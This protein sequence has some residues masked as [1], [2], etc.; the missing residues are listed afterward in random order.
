MYMYIF[1]YIGKEGDEEADKLGILYD[2]NDIIK[3]YVYVYIC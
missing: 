2:E 3:G 1:I